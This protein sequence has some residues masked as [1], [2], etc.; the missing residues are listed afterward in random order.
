HHNCATGYYSFGHEIGHL[1]GA[2]HDRYVDNE[3]TPFPY[4]HG[5]LNGNQWRTI[6]GYGNG[7]DSCQRRNYWSN[8]DVKLGGVATGTDDHENNARVLREEAK[9]IAAFY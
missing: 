5:F 4:G 1:F 2:R 9:R 7:C 3:T 8:P 6:M